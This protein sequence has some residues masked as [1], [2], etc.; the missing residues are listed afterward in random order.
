ME[1]VKLCKDCKHSTPR[2]AAMTFCLHPENVI[3]SPVDGLPE[4]NRSCTVLR[5]N[6]NSCG[7]SGKWWEA[8]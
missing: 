6:E 8:K 4:L 2:Y 1:P 3:V 5:E 7:P